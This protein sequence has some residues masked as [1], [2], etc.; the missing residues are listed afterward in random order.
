MITE[1]CRV[2]EAQK[3]TA[4]IYSMIVETGA[5]S[6]RPG[7]F[8]M[9][10]PAEG[11][12][13]LGRPISVCSCDPQKGVLRLVYRVAGKGTEQFSH[14]AP[15]DEVRI[16]G[17]IG[18]GFDTDADFENALLVGGGIGLP[19]MLGLGEA[20]KKAGR[21]FRFVLGYRDS[22]TFLYGDFEECA[23]KDNI[24]IATDDGSLGVKGTVIDAIAAAG[25]PAR[26]IYACG[27]MPMLRAIKK[28]AA[29]NGIRAYIS[30]EER[31]A[32]GVGACLGCVC[33]TT[34]KDAHSMVNNARVCV[35]GPVFDAMDVDI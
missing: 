1:K 31:M 34:R 18:N 25:I 21:N 29:D 3:L 15:G 8:V 17:P 14:L 7:Q 22:D 6:A 23:G 20:L 26:V 27:P 10:Y 16:T 35:E 12:T 2:T 4:G 28:Y 32:C 9:V 11:S 5:A 13:L 33:K 30:L 24:L 19:P